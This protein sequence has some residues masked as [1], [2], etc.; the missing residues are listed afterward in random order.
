MDLWM[1]E[2]DDP[3]KSRSGIGRM[4]QVR[5]LCFET[6]FESRKQCVDPESVRVM[7]LEVRIRSEVS[8]SVRELGLERA[9]AL[10]LK[11]MSAPVVSMQSSVGVE[12]RELLSDFLTPRQILRQRSFYWRNSCP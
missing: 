11:S 7:M 1:S 10:S 3:S 12:L 9:D 5:R 2:L 4:S 8:H 6:K